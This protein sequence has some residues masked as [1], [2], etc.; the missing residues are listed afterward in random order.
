LPPYGFRR[1]FR[2]GAGPCRSECSTVV[3]FFP[4]VLV[5]AFGVLRNR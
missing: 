5:V 1:S 3:V 4:L 2:V